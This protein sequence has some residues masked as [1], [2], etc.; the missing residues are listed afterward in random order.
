MASMSPVTPAA[1]EPRRST[2]LLSN[3]KPADADADADA[4]AEVGAELEVERERS[5][6]RGGKRRRK[7][8]GKGTGARKRAAKGKRKEPESAAG[9]MEVEDAGSGINGDV[10]PEE[11]DSEEMKLIEE[12]EQADHGEEGSAETRGAR[13][14]VAP[15]RAQRRPEASADHFVGE[16]IPGDKA[17]RLWPSRYETKDSDSRSRRSNDTEEEIGAQ[18]H[19]T[20]A[21][22]DDAIFNLNDDVYVKAGPNEENYIGR[23]TEFFEGTDHVLYFTCRWFFRAEDTVISPNLLEVHDHEHDRKR[24]FLSEEKNDNMIESIISKLNIIYV[25][26]SKTPQERDQLISNSDLY[27]DMSYSVAYSTFAN[28]PAENDGA[29]DSEVASDI[30]C[31]EGKP[32]ADPVG[33]SD[34]RRETATLLD[35]YS[36]CGAMSTGL[37]LGAA[38]SGIKLNTKW[39]VDMNEYACNSLKHNH[40]GTQVRNEKAEDFLALLQHWNALCQ[41]YV[42]HSSN[43][44]GSDLAQMSNDDEDDENEALPNDL[45]EVERLLDI[46]YGDP[47]KTGKD[48]LWFKV[49]WKTYDPSHDSWEPIDGLSDSPECIKEFVQRGYR[50]SILPLPGSVDV[51][52]GGPPCQGISGLNRFRNYNEPLEDDRNKQL[53]VFMDVVNYLRPKYVLMENVVDIL[54]FADGF[55]G[56]YALSRLVSMRYQARLGLMVAGCYGLPQFRM[57]AFLW[58]ALPSR[59]LPKFPLPTHD[60][61]KRGVVPNAF[62]QCLVAYDEIDD[63]RL[64]K[65]LVLQDALSDL[66]KVPNYQPNDLMENRIN[67]KT[68][69]QRYIR[70]SRKDMEDYSFGDA[71]PSPKACQLFDHQPLELS[72]D[73]YQRVK[74][75]PFRKGANFRD[76]KGVQVGENNTVEFNPHIPRVFLPSGKPLVPYYAMTYIKG[77]SPKPFG[78]LWWDETVP[79][80]VTR[81]EPHNQIILHPN[82]HRVLTVRENARLQGFPDYYRLFGP[83]KQ[84]YIQVGNAVAVPVARALGY[85]LGQ[86]YRGA[87]VGGQP[88]FELPEN[89]ASV[90]QAAATASPVG[91]VEK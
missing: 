48:G 18:C 54:K 45:F 76:L 52:C 84:K 70:L 89:F 8:A 67:P 56:R 25:D 43:S 12:E 68:E 82:Q 1:A 80:V 36:G 33:S 74:Q 51:I 34:A 27:Y 19:Y 9:A 41:K 59:V 11:P 90:G 87:L 10:Y 46:C 35:L 30:S 4:E 7:A 40:P 55:L 21:C 23:I 31:E 75:I 39:A 91:V 47:N 71:T 86:A 60:V 62:S 5:T 2:R 50:E 15:P 24:V 64:K 58:G 26:P 79:T 88:L 17:R 14:R 83:I 69:F 13:K 85:S 49:R 16:P 77:K 61:V 63:K 78:R 28:I 29:T 22:V 66:P 42:V 32:V 57:R 72:T 37:C 38:L 6:S 20:S 3:T 73:D 81:A 65:A 44:S 53:V